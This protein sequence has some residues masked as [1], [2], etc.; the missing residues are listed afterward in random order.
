[1]RL[2]IITSFFATVLLPSIVFAGKPGIFSQPLPD[3]EKF[4]C[5]FCPEEVEANN[6][7]NAGLVVVANNSSKFS[8]YRGYDGNSVSMAVDGQYQLID[9]DKY[10]SIK[11]LNAGTSNRQVEMESRRYGRY[12]FNLVFDQMTRF[13]SDSNRTVY[14]GVDSNTLTTPSV[15]NTSAISDTQDVVTLYGNG[16]QYDLKQQRN[17]FDVDF[18]K[19]FSSGWEGRLNY[20]YEKKTGLKTFGGAFSG[21]YNTALSVILPEPIDYVTQMATLSIGYYGSNLKLE[22]GVKGSLFKN[23]NTKIQWDNIYLNN[24]ANEPSKGQAALEPDN[25]FYQVYALGLLRPLS[26]ITAKGQLSAGKMKQDQAFLPYTINE[27]LTLSDLPKTSLDGS[28]NTLTGNFRLSLKPI[29]AL[30][31]YANASLDRKDN[32]TDLASYNYIALDTAASSSSPTRNNL[33]YGYRLYST[34]LATD[35]YYQKNSFF[36]IGYKYQQKSRTYS[37]IAKTKTNFVWGKINQKISN[38]TRISLKVERSERNASDFS[39]VSQINPSQNSLMR[40]YYLADKSRQNIEIDYS[41]ILLNDL[42]FQASMSI[43]KD[44]YSSSSLGV[45]DATDFSYGMDVSKPLAEN[46]FTNAFI[47]IENIESYQKGIDFNSQNWRVYNS[48]TFTTIGLGLDWKEFSDEIDLGSKLIMAFS[49]GEISPERNDANQTEFRDLTTSRV[50]LELYGSY[51]I[52]G[53]MLVKARYILER[54]NESDWHYDDVNAT[55]LDRVLGT[56][57]VSSDYLAHLFLVSLSDSF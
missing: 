53:N 13:Q 29:K 1:M 27:N 20:Q 47:H 41:T 21:N 7:V 2:L 49:K 31:V 44:D 56:Q 4:R 5:K 14:Q 52:K 39:L 33:P 37:E 48:D 11:T 3:T 19:I 12:Q 46:I 25:Q 26:W 6:E 54:Y 9:E 51:A 35:Y 38:K 45:T 28:V 43:A 50:S 15:T 24:N 57:Q 8:E 18:K 30:H 36:N 22:T 17:R 42:N 23:S 10:F 34:S 32:K 40:K 16:S 55:S